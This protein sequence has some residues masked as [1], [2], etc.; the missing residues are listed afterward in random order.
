[1]LPHLGVDSL[2][3]LAL[4]LADRVQAE[5]SWPAL[6]ATLDDA[7]RAGHDPAALL[8][9]ATRRRELHTAASISDV[10]VWRLR[11]SAHLPAAPGNP[12]DTPARGSRR[13]PSPAPTGQQAPSAVNDVDRRR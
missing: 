2:R 11:R 10:L 6:A 3:Q 7:R 1:M 8:S 13:A 5:A 9:E 4:V 12:H